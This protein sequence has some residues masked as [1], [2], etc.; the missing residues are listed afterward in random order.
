MCLMQCMRV[1]KR[2]AYREK[3]GATIGD[4]LNVQTKPRC[5]FCCWV[6]REAKESGTGTHLIGAVR[7]LPL[8]N[9]SAAAGIRIP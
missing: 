5:C 6:I 2:D 1:C 8:L 7:F 3:K 9:L 4:W